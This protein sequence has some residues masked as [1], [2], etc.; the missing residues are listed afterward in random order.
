MSRRKCYP[1]VIVHTCNSSTLKVKTRTS[2]FEASLGYIVSSR[3]TRSQGRWGLFLF[4][5]S[6]INTMT[7]SNLRRKGKGLFHFIDNNLLSIQRR[8]GKSS[9]QVPKEA[10]EAE[11]MEGRAL[12]ACLLCLLRL[13][14]QTIQDHL[15]WM[16]LPTLS[17]TLP[18]QPSIEENALG[19]V[20][21][22]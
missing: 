11:A 19:P 5:F 13:L 8:Q 20:L 18:Q 14:S 10:T 3:Q 9:R 2:K 22:K 6:V 12:L 4:H 1:G 16:V 15:T 17:W 7:K 21:W